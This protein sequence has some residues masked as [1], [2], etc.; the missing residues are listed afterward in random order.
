LN[1]T[2]VLFEKVAKIKK[3]KPAYRTEAE[4]AFETAFTFLSAVKYILKQE[5]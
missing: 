1:D 2:L 4:Q 5:W 3:M